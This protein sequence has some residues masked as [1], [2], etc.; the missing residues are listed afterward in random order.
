MATRNEIHWMK[1]SKKFAEELKRWQK[2]WQQQKGMRISYP[3]LTRVI[4]INNRIRKQ[5]R[6]EL[7]GRK[8]DIVFDSDFWGV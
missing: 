6:K 3:D 5:I 7:F 8:K 4:I 2:M 1:V